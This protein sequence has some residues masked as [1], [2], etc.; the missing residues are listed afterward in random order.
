M[1]NTKVTTAAS[2]ALLALATG[3][4]GTGTTSSE[5]DGADSSGD[6]SIRWLVEEPENA[7]AVKALKAH[8]ATF[9]EESGIDVQV[10]TVPFESFGSIVQ[11]QLRSG[12]GPDV[13]NWGSGPTFG[14]RLA[15]AGL[16]MDLTSAYE[17]RGWEVYDFAKER[18]TVDGKVYGIPGELETIGVF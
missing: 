11:T 4:T 6:G 8:V 5:G 12:E 13:L 16:L 17:E 15:D 2:V 3:C 14:G 7:A 18:V 1:R 9:T 10:S